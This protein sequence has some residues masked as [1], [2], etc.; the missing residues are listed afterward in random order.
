MPL[1]IST[2]EQIEVLRLSTTRSKTL[3]NKT[4]SCFDRASS[5]ATGMSFIMAR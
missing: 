1:A 3:R 4:G 5:K 2:A